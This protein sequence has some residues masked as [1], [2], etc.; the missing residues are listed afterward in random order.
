MTNVL[1]VEDSKITRDSIVRLFS[2]DKDFSVFTTI[3]NA[4][5]AE[6]VCM[7]GKIDLVLMDICTAD[8][9]GITENTVKYHVK[10]IISKTGFK[11]TVQLVAEVVEKRLV[12]PKY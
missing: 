6:I 12:L 9:L 11:N 3:E 2:D 8:H 10:N 5:N 4:A 1:I 7:S